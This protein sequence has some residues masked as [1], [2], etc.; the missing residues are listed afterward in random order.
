MLIKKIFRTLLKTI[1]GFVLFVAVYFILAFGLASITVNSN[2]KNCERDA[3][4]I[5]ILTN[6]V[7]TDLVLPIKN[8][9]INWKKFVNPATTKS[10]DT[11]VNY[12]AFGW[13]DKGFYIETKSWN[14]L[15]FSTAFKAMFFMSTSAMHV[16]FYK[17]LNESETCKKIKINKESYLKLV[18]YI[19]QSFQL[20]GL[21]KTQLIK[22]A[23]YNSNDC[24]YEANR[25]YNLFFTCN[26]WANKGLKSANLKACF[27]T[28][29][30]GAIFKK[31][32]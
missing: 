10:G 23:S 16:T 26:T 18:D 19:S 1:L 6:G 20:D 12:A 15:K 9:F 17:N 29:F 22:N 13:G 32:K 21:S 27:W 3:V 14:E 11:L 4:E 7:H 8:E 2:F 5:Y 24:F 30:E 25:T 28:P 31:Y